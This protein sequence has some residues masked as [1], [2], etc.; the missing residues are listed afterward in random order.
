MT[1]GN[2]TLPISHVPT[3]SGVYLLLKG[4]DVVYVGSA[5]RMRRRLT[6]HRGAPCFRDGNTDG[7][8]YCECPRSLMPLLEG[9]LINGLNPPENRST[10]S[11]AKKRV[12]TY[13][14]AAAK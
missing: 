11:A 7:V 8:V 4:I 1:T 9:A 5:V 6:V 2:L 3:G 13:R 14:T 12:V 10:R